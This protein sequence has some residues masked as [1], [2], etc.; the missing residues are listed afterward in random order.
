MVITHKMTIDLARQERHAPID[1]VQDDCGR[2]LAL[3]LYANGIPWKI[4]AGVCAL[5]R[6]R[7]P[8]G[9]KGEYDT[10]PDGSCAWSAE[11]NLLTV[12]LAPQ[13]LSAVG[14]TCLSILLTDG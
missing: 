9:T 5:V 6:Y 11:E 8:D 3:K 4:P 7:K 2:A 1:T 12:A 13:V 14:S 10:L